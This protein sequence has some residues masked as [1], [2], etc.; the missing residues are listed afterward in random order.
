MELKAQTRTVLGKST[1]KL[2]RQGITPAHIFGP[3]VESRSIQIETAKVRQ[4]LHDGVPKKLT[5]SVGEA[6]VDGSFDVRLDHL[7]LDP[8]HGEI[9]HID[10]LVK[11]A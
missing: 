8:V 3:G 11:R 7:H 9:L 5:L 4:L 6:G 1:K 10:F 2:R